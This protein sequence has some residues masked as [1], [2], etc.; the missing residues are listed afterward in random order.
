MGAAQIAE[1]SQ[2]DLKGPERFKGTVFGVEA[3]ETFTEGG[4]HDDDS[5]LVVTGEDAGTVHSLISP[6][7]REF[8]RGRVRI[9]AGETWKIVVKISSREKKKTDGGRKSPVA[10]PTCFRYSNGVFPSITMAELTV[11]SGSKGVT[12]E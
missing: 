8:C 3:H 11:F 1:V 7:F 9:H 6:E 2:V 4:N 5:P 10:G 12:W